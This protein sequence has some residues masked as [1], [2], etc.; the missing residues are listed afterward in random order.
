MKK[1]GDANLSSL[2]EV[3][4]VDNLEFDPTKTHRNFIIRNFS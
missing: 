2:I 3:F 4:F 1:L